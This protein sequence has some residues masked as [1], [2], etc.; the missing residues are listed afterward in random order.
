ML[1]VV[2]VLMVCGCAGPPVG[3]PAAGVLEIDGRQSVLVECVR[4]VARSGPAIDDVSELRMVSADGDEL[5][6]GWRGEADRWYPIGV[7]GS[8]GD[9]TCSL[10]VD[11]ARGSWVVS[12]ACGSVDVYAEAT[13]CE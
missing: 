12:G 7:S 6:A 1:A 13:G 3:G 10:T 2:V 11:V 4:S 9:A 8:L 5:V